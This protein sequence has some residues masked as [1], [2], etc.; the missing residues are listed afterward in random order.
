MPECKNCGK[1]GLFLKIEEMS[2]L[3]LDCNESFARKGKVLTEQ[4]TAAKTRATIARDPAEI[5]RQSKILVERAEALVALHR[6]YGLEPSHELLDI[7]ATYKK[8]S[9]RADG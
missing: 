7:I 4:I 1:K 9:E 2:G 5:A 3:C 6:A 8:K